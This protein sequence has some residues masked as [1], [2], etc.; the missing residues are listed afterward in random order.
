MVE[1][2]YHIKDVSIKESDII[3]SMDKNDNRN[4]KDRS[5]PWNKKSIWLMMEL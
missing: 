1:S 5:K 4:G 2:T 3:L